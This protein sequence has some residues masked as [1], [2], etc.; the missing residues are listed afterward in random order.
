MGCALC[1]GYGRDQITPL[2]TRHSFGVRVVVAAPEVIAGAPRLINRTWE[3]A[4]EFLERFFFVSRVVE[5]VELWLL[6]HTDEV[7]V[8]S[9]RYINGQFV[10]LRLE[11]EK[12]V[13]LNQAAT[14]SRRSRRP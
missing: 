11:D 12:D 3:I 7:V 5:K 2:S 8:A 10:A 6:T 14:S 4:R 9:Y 13:F 1:S